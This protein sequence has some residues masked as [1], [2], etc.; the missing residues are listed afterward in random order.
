MAGRPFDYEALKKRVP[1][2]I[3]LG[4]VGYAKGCGDLA[5]FLVSDQKSHMTGQA[6]N[7]TG[8]STMN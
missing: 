7:V 5:F 3:P 4:R 1:A 6:I 8:G 2:R